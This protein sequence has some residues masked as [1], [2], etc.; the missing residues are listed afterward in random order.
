MFSAKDIRILPTMAVV[1]PISEDHLWSCES[2]PSRKCASWIM[3]LDDGGRTS[4][5]E[6]PKL[7][8]IKGGGMGKAWWLE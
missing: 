1:I 3:D 2:P 6:A 7:G 8:V 4:A 5:L